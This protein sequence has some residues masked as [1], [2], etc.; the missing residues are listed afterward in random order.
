M[1]KNLAVACTIALT[2]V[3]VSAGPLGPFSDLLV[4]GDSLS[5]PGNAFATL[6]AAA[7]DPAIYPNG[8][9]TNG[10]V[11]ATKLGADLAS[12]TNFAFGGAKAVTD[13]D[14]ALDFAAQRS[15]FF[16]SGLSLGP[17]PLTA[18]FFG[19]ND[20]R[21][22]DP[23]SIGPV[24]TQ[25]VS[26]IA[27]GIG[28]LAATGLREFL[29]F[30]MPDLGKMPSLLGTDAGAAATQVS[31]AFNDALQVALAPLGATVNIQIFDTFNWFNREIQQAAADG[32][33]I[34]QACLEI[35]PICNPTNANSHVNY[36]GLHPTEF[37][38]E[39][40]AQRVA[41]NVVPL[42]AG[43]LLLL[44]GAAALAFFARRKA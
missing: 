13:G 41:A 38:H 4:F 22:A 36:D 25:A 16:S 42:P 40:L 32:K 10:D 30:N 11:W 34:D 35:A 20:V 33:V 2:P 43:L 5:D 18:V 14:L 15:R 29:V 19:S 31:Q 21:A 17:N 12:G 24:I 8:Q 6:G 28:A 44:T 1:L 26:D 7:A 9:F 23:S 39:A 37:V 27:L 3:S